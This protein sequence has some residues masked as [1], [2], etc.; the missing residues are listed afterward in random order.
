MNGRRFSTVPSRRNLMR[1]NRATL[2]ILFA[3]VS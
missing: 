3:E 1:A 2:G